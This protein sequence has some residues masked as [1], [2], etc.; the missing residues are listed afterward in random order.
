[1]KRIVIG[2]TLAAIVCLGV[3]GSAG[4]CRYDDRARSSVGVTPVAGQVYQVDPGSWSCVPLTRDLTV[5]PAAADAAKHDRR[6]VLDD[7][8]R[9]GLV[10]VVPPRT[11]VRVAGPAQEQWMSIVSPVAGEFFGLAGCVPNSWLRATA[12]ATEEPVVTM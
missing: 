2:I 3:A 8:V 6:D 9:R 5:F 12:E 7:L 10:T 4:T 1:M 11:E